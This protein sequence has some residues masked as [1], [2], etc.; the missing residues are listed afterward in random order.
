MD[1]L[2]KIGIDFK[3]LIAQIVNFGVLLLILNKF[4]YKPLIKKLEE[5]SNKIKKIEQEKREI[6][7][8][9][10]EMKKQ[11]E[12]IIRKTKEKA[13]EILQEAEMISKE[14]RERIL[15]RTEKE[16]RHI[17]KEAREKGE[18]EVKRLKEKEEKEI[19]RRA[20]DILAKV[21]KEEIKREFHR[22]YLR[23]IIRELDSFDFKKFKEREVIQVT[24]V[25]AFPLDKKEEREISNLL[26][27]KLENPA[28]QEKID[29]ELIAGIRIYL[30][31]YIIDQSLKGRIEKAI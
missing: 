13:R 28:F 14:E 9:K 25:S 16:V 8:K 4:L 20:K 1:F 21:L 5:R 17:L 2:E 18:L 3:L 26:F 23:E 19:L 10:E 30:N 24:I 31:G 6:E 12:E 22:K 15:E 29:P 27:K 11:E 7:R